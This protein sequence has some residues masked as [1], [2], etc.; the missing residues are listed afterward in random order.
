MGSFVPPG[1]A[2][3]VGNDD[4]QA[5]HFEEGIYSC[6]RAQNL[7]GDSALII[8]SPHAVVLAHISTTSNCRFLAATAI[9]YYENHPNLFPPGNTR[10]WIICDA[11]PWPVAHFHET[12]MYLMLN[13]AGLIP[14]N[15]TY[16]VSDQSR[17]QGH[18]TGDVIVAATGRGIVVRVEGRPI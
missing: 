14:R 15:A 17:Q 8:A 18:G 12:T 2:L 6:I 16:A 1:A 13:E 4:I 7:N 9:V 3:E 10:A 11:C 5:V